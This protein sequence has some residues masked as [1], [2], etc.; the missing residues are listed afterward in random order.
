MLGSIINAAAILIGACVGLMLRGGISQ[1]FRDTVMQGLAL[2]VLLIGIKGAIGTTDIMVV[3]LCIAIG[4][5]VGEGINIEKRLDSLGA[6]AQ[7]IF[8]R[9]SGEG[10]HSFAQGF[11]TT[12]LIYCVGAMAIV[13]SMDAGLKGD[14]ATLIAK[15]GLD[16]I[17]AVIFASS[18]G[19]GVALSGAS[20]LLYQGAITLLSHYVA[21][22]LSAAVI[23]EMSAVGGLLIIGLSLNMLGI[24][25]LKVGN[26]LPAVF[27]PPLILPLM[28]WI[29]ALIA[30]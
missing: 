19:V 8:A 21:P 25:K 2:C 15:S 16:G 24:T 10:D 13:G 23:A 18:M 20:V 7:R 4:A 26:L 27:L 12:S 3:I 17:S 5:V 9:K 6:H 1:R 29:T 28:Q 11:V 22:Y 14:Y 30:R